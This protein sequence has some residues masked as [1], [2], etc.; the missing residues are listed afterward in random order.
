M[1]LRV[2]I[3]FNFIS[4]S[5]LTFSQNDSIFLR[6][7]NVYACKIISEDSNKVEFKTLINGKN[8][9]TFINKIY[10][11]SIKYNEN[12]F[13]NN[14]ESSSINLGFGYGPSFGII[15]TRTILG[16][17]DSGFLLGLGYTPHGQFSKAIGFQITLN[18][19]FFNIGVG[20]IA[21]VQSNSGKTEVIDGLFYNI[22]AR[23]DLSKTRRYNLEIG[24]GNI[25]NPE[26]N[27][28]SGSNYFYYRGSIGLNYR[29]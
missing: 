26:L 11:T 18:W 1:L 25:S 24:L 16:Y 8:K 4:I 19:F 28:I 13:L 9:E 23:I 22:G 2:L 7:G 14:V 6:N 29:F 21:E 17:N 10:V 15:G 12:E 5:Y 27:R 20:T 3:I